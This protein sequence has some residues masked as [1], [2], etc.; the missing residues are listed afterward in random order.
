MNLSTATPTTSSRL[1]RYPLRLALVTTALAAACAVALPAFAQPMGPGGH[2]HGMHGARGDH[3]G[4]MGAG[5]G[6][7]ERMLDEVKA[8]SEQKA[9]IRQIME[10]ARKDMQAQREAGKAL[11]EESMRVFTA[12]NVDANA[13]EALRQKRLAQH[14]QAS[15]RMSQALLDASRVLT[16]EQRKLIAERMQKRQQMME[17]H[18]NERHQMEG[19]KS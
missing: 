11:R 6:M 12:P 14:D 2:G 8:S 1:A 4:G 16:P 3:H 9:Q 13:V 18:R 19:R 10:A 5:M 7:S 15:R 17:R